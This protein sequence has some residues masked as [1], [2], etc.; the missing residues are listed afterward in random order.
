MSSPSRKLQKIQKIKKVKVRQY[1]CTYLKFGF[2]T[3]RHDATRPMCLVCGS[4]FTNEAIKPNRL[5]HHLNR[6]HPNKIS[7]DF[8][9][10]RD[11]EA[12]QT[13][14]RSLFKQTDKPQN[15]A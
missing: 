8:K 7:S 15:I 2:T 3:A 6:M 4:I 1:I 5:L 13:T 10:L 11:E 12:K 14:I 9:K